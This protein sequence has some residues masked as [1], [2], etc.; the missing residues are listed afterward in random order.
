MTKIVLEMGRKYRFSWEENRP[1]HDFL[2]YFPEAGGQKPIKKL[3]GMDGKI[4]GFFEKV[5]SKQ[6]GEKNP[7]WR[8]YQFLSGNHRNWPFSHI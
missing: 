1:N 2:P 8:F 4:E 5:P 7:F 6:Q 3:P